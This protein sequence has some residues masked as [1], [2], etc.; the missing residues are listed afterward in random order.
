MAD[1]PT[2]DP[3]LD[4]AIRLADLDALIRLIDARST[5]HDWEGITQIRT[6]CRAAMST[7][8]QLWPAA[9]LAE[10]RLV[11]WAPAESAAHILAATA[12]VGSVNVPRPGPLT[13]VIAQQHTWAELEPWLTDPILR[14]YVA[15][16][17]ALRGEDLSALDAAQTELM[18]QI[19]PTPL[20]HAAW[21]PAYRVPTYT[22][23]GVRN[24]PP[25][26]PRPAT[27]VTTGGISASSSVLVDDQAEAVREAWLALVRPW[28]TESNGTAQAVGV[29]GDIDLALGAL[30]VENAR[31]VEMPTP[32]ALEWLMWAGAEGGAHGRRRGG[33]AGRDALWWL[34]GALGDL[35]DDWPPTTDEM[36]ELMA[37]LRW[38]WW[39]STAATPGWG[40]RIVCQDAPHGVTWAF[41]AH[42]AV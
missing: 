28:L 41:A 40:L 23:Q 19:L 42:D 16:E 4:E 6:A 9:A 20:H 15:H 10:Y 18:G 8:R 27:E 5:H 32:L 2:S 3:D 14:T 34:L 26:A 25:A 31:I 37:D 13:E 29:Q 22:D 11:L 30:G 33:A 39:E 35:T 17:R 12:D 7:G 36:A 38:W 24:E 1:H 21:E